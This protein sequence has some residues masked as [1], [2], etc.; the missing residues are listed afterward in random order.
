[1][2]DSAIDRQGIAAEFGHNPLREGQ[3]NAGL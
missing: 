3:R 1:M 2:G